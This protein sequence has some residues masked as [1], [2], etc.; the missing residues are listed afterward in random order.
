MGKQNY[1]ATFRRMV[2][3]LTVFLSN[4]KTSEKQK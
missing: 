1:L 3:T 4:R 2:K